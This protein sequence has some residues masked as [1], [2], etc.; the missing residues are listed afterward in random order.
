MSSK[1][2]DFNAI[3]GLVTIFIGLVYII[4]SYLVPRARIGNPLDPIYFPS[5][6]GVLMTLFGIILFIRSEKTHMIDSLKELKNMSDTEKKVMRMIIIT[7]TCGALYAL[8]FEHAGFVISTIFF[9][10]GILFMTNGK[11]IVTNLVV[12]VFFSV[13]IFI[14]FNH[15]LGI[16]L[17]KAFGLF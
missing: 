15:G 11:K 7:C 10:L 14:L 9:L 5:G 2:L 13:G 16:T 6:L 1:K 12:S 17:P 8:I 3:T 4:M